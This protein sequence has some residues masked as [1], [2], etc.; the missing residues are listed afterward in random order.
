MSDFHLGD[1]LLTRYDAFGLIH[2]HGIYVGDGAIIH[3]T[4]QSNTVEIT[5]G[6]GF[7]GG[8][9]IAVKRHAPNATL[10]VNRAYAQLDTGHYHWLFNNCE[11][12]VNH[13]L[14]GQAY[15]QQVG[16]AY[17]ATGALATRM[18]WLGTAAQ[19]R[20]SQAPVWSLGL[21]TCVIAAP[22]EVTVTGLYRTVSDSTGSLLDGEIVTATEQLL[23]GVVDTALNATQTL[24]LTLVDDIVQV[25]EAMDELW[26]WLWH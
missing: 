10:A 23:T 5:D 13:C 6:W 1:H 21:G 9:P 25:S 16:Q 4:P 15:S 2:H 18:G 17:V 7:A 3:L 22:L 12:L 11:H 14:D 24:V 26:D 19:Q 8:E 20:L